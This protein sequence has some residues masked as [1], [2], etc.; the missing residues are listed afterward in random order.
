MPV[1]VIQ[2]E[3]LSTNPPT[4]IYPLPL[5]FYPKPEPYCPPAIVPIEIQIYPTATTP[6]PGTILV[7]TTG[8]TPSGYLLCNGQEVSRT[9]YSVLFN[10][11]GTYYGDGDLTTTF[12]IPNLTNDCNPNTQYIIKI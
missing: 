4:P 12:N 11:I 9:T 2:R 7:N 8:S 6:P 1:P 3:F 10:V 5:P